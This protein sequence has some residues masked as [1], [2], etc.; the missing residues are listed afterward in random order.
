MVAYLFKLT[1]TLLNLDLDLFSMLGYIFLES[2]F[3]LQYVSHST[4]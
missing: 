1:P 3:L 4:L 2:R